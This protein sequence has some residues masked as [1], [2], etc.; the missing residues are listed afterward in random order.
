[1]GIQELREKHHKAMEYAQYAM[2]ANHNGDESE[3]ETLSGLAFDIEW[4]VAQAVEGNL[5]RA[6]LSKSSAWLA[7]QAKRYDDAQKT[8]DYGL[9]GE[10]V[11]EQIEEELHEAQAELNRLIE[12]EGTK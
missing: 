8:I 5:D 10:Y 7:I 12:L 3:H 4:E 2:L 6:I 11:P 9:S 1:M